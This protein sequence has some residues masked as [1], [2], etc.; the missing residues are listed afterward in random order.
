LVEKRVLEIGDGDSVSPEEPFFE[1][2][3]EGCFE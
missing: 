3:N 2:L 1:L